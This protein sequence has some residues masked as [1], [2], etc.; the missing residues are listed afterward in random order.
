M[1][2]KYISTACTKLLTDLEF[3]HLKR[4]DRLAMKY[5]VETRCPF[6]DDKVVQI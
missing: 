5:T 1:T 3:G 4:V 2:E 6:L